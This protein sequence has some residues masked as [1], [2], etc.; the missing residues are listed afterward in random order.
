MNAHK[1]TAIAT[2]TD[3][4]LITSNTPSRPATKTWTEEPTAHAQRR[5]ASRALLSFLAVIMLMMGVLTTTGCAHSNGP[6]FNPTA[7]AF[8]PQ[9][10]HPVQASVEPEAPIAEEPIEQAANPVLVDEPAHRL[11][12]CR[13][14]DCERP[15]IEQPAPSPRFR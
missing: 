13:V 1:Y 10:E 7:D 5:A 14:I 8:A 3:A 15:L 11:G 4:Q 2:L 12:A 6:L 9:L